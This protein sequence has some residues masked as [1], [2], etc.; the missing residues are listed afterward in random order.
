MNKK[1][2]MLLTLLMLTS[3]GLTVDDN[4]LLNLDGVNFTP[5]TS[6]N[7]EDVE[8]DISIPLTDETFYLY[9]QGEYT[10]KCEV[11][12]L[13]YEYT[14]Y[15][16]IDVDFIEQDKLYDKIYESVNNNLEY[17]NQTLNEN[18]TI[19]KNE[20][21]VI[22]EESLTNVFK[23]EVSFMYVDRFLPLRLK[24]NKND[25]VYTVSIPLSRRHLVKNDSHIISPIDD[26]IIELNM[27]YQLK[28]YV[29]NKFY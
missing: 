15:Y 13:N 14:I 1:I 18:I 29:L 10:S 7:L 19:Y 23:G 20:Q 4:S 3:C 17:I 6:F 25:E 16:L 27:F 9:K 11:W 26:T 5:L 8:Y 21:N 24:N 2:A 28:N 12:T 22:I